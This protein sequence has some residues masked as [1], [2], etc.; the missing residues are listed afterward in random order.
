MLVP[1]PHLDLMK[2]LLVDYATLSVYA[3]ALKMEEP[4]TVE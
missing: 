4:I 3:S 2:V 1:L